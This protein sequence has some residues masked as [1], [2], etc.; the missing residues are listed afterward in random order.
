MNNDQMPR[1][2]ML[3]LGPDSLSDYELIAI[4]LQSGTKGENV[5]DA[6]KRIISKMPIYKLRNMSIH[7]LIDFKGIGIAKACIIIAAFELSKRGEMPKPGKQI[8]SAKD[9]FKLMSNHAD[10]TKEKVISLLLNSR[11][12][13]IHKDLVGI[14]TLN[15]VLVHPREVFNCAIRN[16]ANGIILVHNH[17]SGDVTPSDE[18]FRITKVLYDSGEIIGINL[19]D[20]VIVSDGK[21]FSFKEEGYL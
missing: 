13:I 2:R 3:S 8:R 14:G 6:A 10:N 11:N 15:S 17:P 7:E 1:E 5:L 18:D 19:I 4:L 9:V 12:L 20:H 21:Y 16:S